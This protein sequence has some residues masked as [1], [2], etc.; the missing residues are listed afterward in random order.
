M[1]SVF[2]RKPLP[3][4]QLHHSRVITATVRLLVTVLA[5]LLYWT[6]GLGFG[7]NA[8]GGTVNYAYDAL[9]RLIAVYDPSGN[10]AVY[11]YDAVGN[12]LSI[13]NIAAG[14]FSGIELGSG[15]GTSGSNL[16]IYGTGF[17]SNPTV[18]FNG[19]TA[20]VISATT[21]QIVVTVPAGNVTGSVVVACGSNNVTIGTFTLLSAGGA[22][23]I[24]GF[25]PTSGAA[26]TSV[27]ISGANFQTTPANNF[28]EFDISDASVSSATT[29]A[30]VA[31]V[32]GVASTGPITIS[33]DYGQAVSSTDFFVPPPGASGTLDATAQLTLGTAST[34]TIGSGYG[35]FAFNGSAGQM[36]SITVS[37]AFNCGSMYVFTPT[38]QLLES[39]TNFCGY[40]TFADT[41][42]LPQTG[43]YTIQ[44]T[45]GSG[46]VTV[47]AYNVVNNVG[48]IAVGGPPVTVTDSTPGENPALIFSGTAGQMVALQLSNS[49]QYPCCSHTL[50]ILNPDST[51][52]TSTYF[53]TS[54]YDLY[55]TTLG[56]VMLPSTGTYSAVIDFAGGVT[57]NG[58]EQIFNY[59]DQASTVSTSASYPQAVLADHPSQ[60]WRLNESS[61]VFQATSAATTYNTG[62]PSATGLTFG[63]TGALDGD[64]NT[65]M[66]FDGS[67][68]QV[69]LPLI[70]NAAGSVTLECWVKIAA[71]THGALLEIGNSSSGYSGYGIGI[72]N[73]NFDTTG[74]NLI[75]LY[76]G[77][78][79]L[80]PTGNPALSLNAW[81][82]VAL[83]ID[84]SGSPTVYLD[85]TAYTVSGSGGPS[86]PT[87]SSS[88]GNDPA[89]STRHVA[90][91][92]DEPAIYW[93]ALSAA[94]ISNHYLGGITNPSNYASAGVTGGANYKAVI[95]TD[96]P[97][98]Y[99]RLDE[100][101]TAPA[102][103]DSAVQIGNNGFYQG[104]VTMG[105]TGVN[106]GDTAVTLNGS[107]GYIGTVLP[108]SGAN[109]YSLEMWFKTTTTSG[110]KLIGFGN[111][112]TGQSSSYDRQIYMTNSGSLIFGIFDGSGH[113]VQTSSS[114]ND[115]NWH[116][117]VGTWG[118][119]TMKLYVDNN[120]SVCGGA[121]TTAGGEQAYSGYW[122][123]GY[124][125]LA[126]W[127]SAPS[128]YYFSGTIDEAAVYNYAL[129]ATQVS[130]HYSSR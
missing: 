34:R 114:Y 29:T 106:T 7:R 5:L 87:G 64:S 63:V 1:S 42:T 100:T 122:R 116:Y 75:A 108:Y 105:V 73:G 85:G 12:L 4:P 13:T 55:G 69:N 117:V 54:A 14:T 27:T 127:P 10:A 124:D 15:S 89:N 2:Q 95:L 40:G 24:T 130:N 9:G 38:N 37:T 86:S 126:W 28:V 47:T 112:M 103:V 88:I 45:G 44:V 94:Q 52:L 8:L 71:A 96:Q 121:C 6:L 125:N 80:L 104:G 66:A 76:E 21:T 120:N 109:P 129:S 36:V 20:N 19:V 74:T 59:T 16:T 53:R 35:L 17:C 32:P 62:T 23:T 92:I 102:I 61:G 57:G 65:A 48:N 81:H 49:S 39:S 101:S 18:T 93:T 77:Q 83:V 90:A 33:T 72:G 25:V 60:Y 22:P 56:P 51:L 3:E 128:S 68:G 70:S 99:Y 50:K 115:G 30:L 119:N 58:V 43:T 79:W 97:V 31:T 113:T 91:S 123:L 46:N 67:S 118:N 78:R 41:K 11:K 110:G 26:G 84:G 98:A 107:S 82:H 111:A